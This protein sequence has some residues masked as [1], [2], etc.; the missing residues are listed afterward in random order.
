[1][2]LDDKTAITAKT[3]DNLA[4]K[5]EAVYGRKITYQK[6]LDE[7]VKTLPKDAKILDVGCGTGHV[8]AYLAELGFDVTGIDISENM[9]EIA[10]DKAPLAQFQIMDLRHM[11]F[12]DE[13]FDAILAIFSLIHIS[14]EE[15]HKAINHFAKIL[16]PQGQLFLGL[17]EGESETFAEHSFND[18]HKILFQYYDKQLIKE[19]L[20]KEGFI[21]NT[22]ADRH[23]TDD[24]QD[25][26]EFF[27]SA[28]KKS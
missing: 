22:I 13:S 6:E 15:A 12:A 26:D 24:Y 20:D 1:M 19:I 17:V 11:D 4:K 27:I 9:I 18:E 25:Q 8:D 23:Y 10:V 28:Q 2:P 16:R 3:Y 21:V 14:K 5:Y 7:F